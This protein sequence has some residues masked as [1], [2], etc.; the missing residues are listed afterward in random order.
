VATPLDSIV[1]PALRAVG[2]VAGGEVGTPEEGNDAFNLLNDLIDQC[3]AEPGM[4][5][6]KQEIIHELT[7]GQYIYT[8]GP[9]GQV[10]ASFTGSISGNAMTVA[11][12]T[13]GALSVG[14]IIQSDPSATGSI[15]GVDIDPGLFFT[16]QPSISFAGDGAGAVGVCYAIVRTHGVTVGATGSGYKAGQLLTLLGGTFIRP[17]TLRITAT[18][19]GSG[20][21]GFVTED[22][23]AYITIPA[24]N[25]AL[26]GG[27]G[28]GAQATIGGVWG[29]GNGIVTAGGIG[30]TFAT[31]TISGGGGAGAEA[32]A[33]IGGQNLTANTSITSYGTGLGGNGIS[34]LG[35]YNLNYAQTTFAGQPF[36][37]YSPRPLRINSAIVR[38]PS[39]N[40][41]LDYIVNVINLE[42]YERIGLKQ[43]NGP[44]PRA[45]YYQPSEPL[46]I[47]NYWPNPSQGEMHL[48]CDMLFPRFSTL[49]D[50]ITLPQGYINAF[51]WMLAEIQ[52]G[53]A[54]V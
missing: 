42:N 39:S 37:S 13:S 26:S 46:G 11:S 10:G 14:Q 36:I 34:A 15:V 29:A 38:I 33:I 4:L 22:G 41:N 1:L 30:Y 23:G 21:A 44:W 24:D 53:R 40:G 31:A 27:T 49:Q 43:L 32:A 12:L 3:S 25:V 19:G 20:V 47:L 48:F 35:T 50:T 18:V 45:V 7:S 5:F 16:G 52:I 54:H 28:S 2:A 8:I 17:A 51:K 6:A 9:G